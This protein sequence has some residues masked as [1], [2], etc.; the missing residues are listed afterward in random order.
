MG[1]A[2]GLIQKLGKEI[3]KLFKIPVSYVIFAVVLVKYLYSS[4][5]S[6]VFDRAFKDRQ[7]VNHIV[8]SK[9]PRQ[10]WF[11]VAEAE[12]LAYTGLKIIDW[13]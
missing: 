8:A 3:Q 6:A 5:L 13:G 11:S 1:E 7:K 9:Q 10:Q 12:E 2:I 4:E